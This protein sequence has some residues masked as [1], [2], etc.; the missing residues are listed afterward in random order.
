MQAMGDGTLQESSFC[1]L[2]LRA[3]FLIQKSILITSSPPLLC[4]ILEFWP[5]EELLLLFFTILPPKA[6]SYTAMSGE[7]ASSA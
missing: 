6:G 4:Q 7:K 3:S 5:W 2:T 1:T